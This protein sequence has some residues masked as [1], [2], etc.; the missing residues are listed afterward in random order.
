[1]ENG[2]WQFVSRR[3]GGRRTNRKCRPGGITGLFTSSSAK[4]KSNAFFSFEGLQEQ[5]GTSER[6]QRA[7]V[8][9]VVKSIEQLV[10]QVQL[11]NLWKDIQCKFLDA[12]RA[13]LE[14]IQ[15]Q[16][17]KSEEKHLCQYAK[18]DLQDEP[19]SEFWTAGEKVAY[20]LVCLGL[21]S[22][23]ACSDT[24]SCRYQLALAVLLQQ[25]LAI[26]C[27]R[28]RI[29]DPVMNEVDYQVLVALSL[30]SDHDAEARE[31]Q[32]PAGEKAELV[33]YLAPH[34]DADLYGDILGAEL[35]IQRFCVKCFACADSRLD[36][37]KDASSSFESSYSKK[38]CGSR[39]R[40]RGFVLI[41]NT[42]TSYEMRRQFFGDLRFDHWP[43]ATP[44]CNSLVLPS[45]TNCVS[46]TFGGPCESLFSI[47]GRVLAN[48]LQ[49][50]GWEASEQT[51]AC[52]S[53]CASGDVQHQMGSAAS[54]ASEPCPGM[55]SSVECCRGDTRAA[56]RWV[57]PS[58][59]AFLLLALLPFVSE[60]PLEQPFPLHPRAFNDLAVSRFRAPRTEA[61]RAFFWRE[62]LRQ[63]KHF[64]KKDRHRR[65]R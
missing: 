45:E 32:Q 41:G 26:P 25:L 13:E 54:E 29:T 10:K 5:D 46:G 17:V 15:A 59:G 52:V 35:G 57:I 7:T 4:N 1:M 60:W 48:K 24:L 23:T 6:E 21:G 36:A 3:Q 44:A 51:Q 27:S 42:L 43:R 47:S 14:F 61:Q 28:V 56:C 19:I 37:R 20:S 30:L 39:S 63:E 49:E 33:L 11:S 18:K 65:R 55:R 64:Q 53:M 12:V 2:E 50:K 40:P 38:L 62:A 9:C 22:P 8:E 34:C 16:R 31:L 58:R